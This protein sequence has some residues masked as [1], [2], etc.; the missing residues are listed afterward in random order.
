MQIG[1]SSSE[2]NLYTNNRR[3]ENY[4]SDL[5]PMSL[6]LFCFPLTVIV[7]VLQFPDKWSG[8]HLIFLYSKHALCLNGFL[9]REPTSTKFQN[10]TYVEF[11]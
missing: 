10:G 7:H 8:A 5:I 9:T 11:I 1:A 3:L 2:L 4:A 6:E